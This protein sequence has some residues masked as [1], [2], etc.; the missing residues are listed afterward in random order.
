MDEQEAEQVYAYTPGLNV[1]KKIKIRKR[2]ILPLIGE[3]IVEKGDTVDFDTIVARAYAPGE[4]EIIN[5]APILGVSKERLDQYM[6]K[7][8]GDKLEEGE[9]IAENI[10]L[11]GLIKRY[12]RAPFDCTLE[13][14]SE[15][16]GRIIV[17]GAPVPVEVTSYIPGEIIEVIPNQGVVIETEASFIQGIFGVGRESNGEIQFVVDSPDQ[18]I[19]VD[20]V[21]PEHQGKILI[22]GSYITGDALEKA[23][24]LGVTG[25]V[26]GGISSKDLKD[27]IGYEIGVAITGEEDIGLTLIATESFGEM[28][29][30]RHT[31]DLLKEL[32]GLKASINGATQIRAGVLRP[33]IIVPY[34]NQEIGKVEEQE[35]ELEQG[36]TMGTRIRVIRAPYFGKLGVV[37]RLPAGLQQLETESMARVLEVK[38]DDGNTGIVPR[39]NVEIIVE[40]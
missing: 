10:F 2:R 14:I 8:A 30:A 6:V 32:E 34:Q 13:N 24:E 31:F 12:C 35:P 28:P 15:Y 29:M 20:M 5:A 18:P 37:S 39:A 40:K 16:S 3:V 33:E 7:E 22:G 27:F 19:T 26:T 25:I 1:T 17:R 11:F 36:M 4:P 38:F 23:V 9:V 21:K